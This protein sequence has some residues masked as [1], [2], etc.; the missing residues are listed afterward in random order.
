MHAREDG[1]SYFS[2]EPPFFHDEPQRSFPAG[3]KG[4]TVPAKKGP[5]KG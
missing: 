2:D 5:E 4:G 1:Q 3:G